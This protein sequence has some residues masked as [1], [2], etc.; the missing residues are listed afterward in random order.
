[1]HTTMWGHLYLGMLIWGGQACT[2]LCCVTLVPKPKERS[3]ASSCACTPEPISTSPG[4]CDPAQTR[5]VFGE[6]RRG[7]A[8]VHAHSPSCSMFHYSPRRWGVDRAKAR[9]LFRLPWVIVLCSASWQ[10]V[11]NLCPAINLLV[12]Q[13]CAK[14]LQTSYSNMKLK[15]EKNGEI[16]MGRGE[17][18]LAQKGP[19]WKGRCQQLQ[20]PCQTVVH[21]GKCIF[22]CA[23][24]SRCIYP[25]GQELINQVKKKSEY[26]K[27]QKS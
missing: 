17:C 24:F 21:P 5:C 13:S 8:H 16:G 15:K 2:F 4:L 11:L 14:Q 22:C 23:D 27:R 26:E 25:S 12:D 19:M 7:N 10:S 20:G 18:A 6:H 1:M 3:A 9:S